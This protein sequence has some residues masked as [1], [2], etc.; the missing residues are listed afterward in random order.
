[1]TLDKDDVFLGLDIV[2]NS[3]RMVEAERQ[4]GRLI[5]SNVA[6]STLDLPFDF[7]AIGNEEFIPR[8][9]SA[10][11]SLLDKAAIRARTAYLALE[12]RMLLIKQFKMDL[13]LN[14]EDLRQHVE[15]ELSQI[16]VSA[17]DEY[18]VGCER[19]GQTSDLLEN[20]VVAAVRKSIVLYLKEIFMQ[21]PLKLAAI[22]VDLFAA[23]RALANT[24]AETPRGF[25]ALVDINERGIDFGL[26]NEGKYFNSSEISNLRTN[27][28]RTNFLEGSS[29][30][31]AR[32]VNDEIVRLLENSDN[33]RVTKTL[34]KVYLTG[35][36]A[37]SDII[38]HLQ[39]LQAAAEIAF[40]DPFRNIETRLS[41]ESE[42]LI[43][44]HPEMFLASVGMVLT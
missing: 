18:N 19:L 40:A 16:L 9:A 39:K 6:H 38:P 17:R 29:E 5:L 25:T 44:L 26:I 43:K 13:G 21:T 30:E 34:A 31:I 7:Y 14:D 27:G 10:I 23:I 36:R 42:S 37:E 2:G 20:V 12:R 11:N 4:A 24:E 22:D 35:D 1:M 41:A 33:N 3:L 32:V 28:D 15:W 8:F